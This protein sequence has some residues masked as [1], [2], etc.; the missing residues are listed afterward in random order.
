MTAAAKPTFLRQTLGPLFLILICPPTAI[1]FWYTNVHL[2]GSFQI[3]FERFFT[4]GL[5]TT[6]Y[7]AWA[8]VFFGSKTAWAI[9]GV[10][11]AVQLLFMKIL[12]GKT[13]HGPITPKGNVPLYKANGV[14][15]FAATLT[16]FFLCA[17]QF[18]LFSPTI[19]YDNF[20]YLLGA[21]NIFSLFFCLIL[22]IKGHIAPSSSDS[23][24]SGNWIFDYYWGTELY[25]R[26]LGWDIKMFTNC[27]FGL[28]SWAV[29]ILCFA[30]KQKQIYGE[31]SDSMLVA[32][33]LQL[34]YITKFFF[35]ETGYLSSLDIMHDRAGYYICWG[36]LVWV[37]GIYTSATLYL[38]NH[39]NH[40]GWPL[41][42]AIFVVGAVCILINYWA[43]WQRQNVRAL[44]GKC[45][46]W[47]RKPTLI[48]A[49]YMTE[50]G[51][52]KKSLLLTCG[53]WGIARHFHYVPEILGSFFW[54]VPAL[55]VDFLPYFYVVYL[56]ILLA[57]RAFRDE[58]RC[59]DKYG[60]DWKVYCEHV[61]YK[62][63]PGII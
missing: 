59:S 55:F 56:T 44:R 20:G 35:W 23:G 63:L 28:M 3:L 25:P 34:I 21:L 52:A 12:P 53:W 41:A 48:E 29:I 22:L 51:E 46:V 60:D 16:L 17:Y 10:F 38:V 30:A 37:P 18:Q 14:F 43:D 61:P 33:A 50:T 4:H 15:A 24:A 26:I 8:P 45:T 7:D 40:L 57:D 47:G 39:P 54:S 9:L 49:C 31:V 5:L 6:V 27:R 42:S 32:V 1:L 36:C 62:I 2:Q 58:K 11:S 19:V 13:F